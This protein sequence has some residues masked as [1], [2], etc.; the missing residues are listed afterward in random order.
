MSLPGE[1]SDIFH[2]FKSISCALVAYS[3]AMNL[4]PIYSSLKIKTNEYMTK[5]VSYG[6]ALTSFIYLFLAIV[7]IMLFGYSVDAST[8]VMDEVNKEY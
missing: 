4:F 2:I 1:T 7:S 6:I 8:N 5:T 3:F